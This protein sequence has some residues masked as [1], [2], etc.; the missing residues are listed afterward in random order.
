MQ[1]LGELL[2]EQEASKLTIER[3]MAVF[4][5]SDSR[6]KRILVRH[7]LTGMCETSDV[8]DEQ[9]VAV[10]DGL[11]RPTEGVRAD[12]FPDNLSHGIRSVS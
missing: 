5:S 2:A 3:I 8:T 4:N 12:Q 9:F 10:V 7:A 6:G 1:K 11:C